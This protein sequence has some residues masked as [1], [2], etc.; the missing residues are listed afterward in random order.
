M[1]GDFSAKIG[2]EDIF[3]PTVGIESL[4]KISNDSVVRVPNFAA[5]K[6]LTV[7]SMMFPH[8]NIHTFTWTFPDGK[9]HNQIHHIL[10]D[11]R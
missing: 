8:H 4:H 9:T 7:K 6:N 10:I 2:R 11:G 5:Y 3:K 1:L